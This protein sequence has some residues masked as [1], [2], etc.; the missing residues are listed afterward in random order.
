MV[1]N[2]LARHFPLDGDGGSEGR[3]DAGVTL[4]DFRQNSIGEHWH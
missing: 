4:A 2:P 1:P 3:Q